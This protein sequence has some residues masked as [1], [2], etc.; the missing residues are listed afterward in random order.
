MAPITMYVAQG[1]LR[2]SVVLDQN[3][4]IHFFTCSL[5]LLLHLD[6]AL[7]IQSSFSFQIQH[8]CFEV[9]KPDV[10]ATTLKNF[11]N[12]ERLFPLAMSCFKVHFRNKHF[13]IHEHNS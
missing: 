11:K 4:K 3:L 9:M 2:G 10:S 6:L 7:C 8:Y 12:T 13:L 5:Y 1:Q